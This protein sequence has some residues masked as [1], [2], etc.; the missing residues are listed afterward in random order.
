MSKKFCNLLSFIKDHNKELVQ[1]AE[2]LCAS[3]L[4]SGMGAKTFLNPTTKMVKDLQDMIDRGDSDK[5]LEHLKSLFLEGD[6]DVNSTGT[7][8]TF[9]RKEVTNLNT[10][11]NSKFNAW[12]SNI[13]VYNIKEF[14]TEGKESTKTS[15][16]AKGESIAGG[17]ESIVRVDVSNDLINQYMLTKDHKV[18]AYAVNSLLSFLKNKDSEVYNEV[19]K[20]LDPNMILSWY[21]LVQPTA[22]MSNKHISDSLF[23]KWSKT[24][25]KSPVKSVDLIRELMS[26]NNY[27]N[28]DLKNII[29]ERKKIKAVGLKDTISD[30]CKA[31]GENYCKL[32]EDE[33]RFRFSDLKEFDYEDIMTLNLIDWDSP[34]K[35][36]LLFGNIPKSNL[37]QSE[38]YKLITQFIKS[39]AFLYTPYNDDIM[40]KIN[41]TISGAGGYANNSLYICGG[42][43]RS[44]IQQMSSGGLDFS[45]EAFVGGLNSSQITELK[46]Y[47]N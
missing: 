37:L 36:L 24:L 28:K 23:Q 38:I 27:D 12:K 9:N 35:N 4:F 31:Y 34:K 29:E 2:D 20:V 16:K 7:Y 17:K 8:T 19:H 18:Y 47:L 30:V 3:N 43:N 6:N 14:P 41:N 22:R 40:K 45:L 1:V 11:N 42:S 33:L 13:K 44:D 25:Y 46:S 32:L 26:S 5:A 10:E 39:N 15:K 21:I